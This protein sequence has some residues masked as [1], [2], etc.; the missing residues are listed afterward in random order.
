MS[1]SSL[2][3]KE[4][5]LYSDG[6]DGHQWTVQP[7]TLVT[8]PIEHSF[9]G[10]FSYVSTWSDQVLTKTS[11][12]ASFDDT[13][14]QYTFYSED[15]D[16]VGETEYMLF[17]WLEQYEDLLSERPADEV[18]GSLKILGGCSAPQDLIVP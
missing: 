4:Y 11:K 2:P 15:L 5:V 18:K 12:P 9:C 3:D 8:S 13:S 1:M 10:D 16:L 14:L 17:G 7:F 6:P